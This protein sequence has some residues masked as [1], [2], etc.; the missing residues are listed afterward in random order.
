MQ[1]KKLTIITFVTQDRQTW[2][3]NIIMNSVIIVARYLNKTFSGTH[4]LNILNILKFFVCVVTHFD[5]YTE[6]NINVNTHL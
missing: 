3:R 4:F 6:K 2:F 5:V 1:R